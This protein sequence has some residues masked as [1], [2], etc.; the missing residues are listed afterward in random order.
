VS[1]YTACPG[2]HVSAEMHICVSL[3]LCTVKGR[4][5]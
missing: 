4:A 2:L 1:A 5:I 3:C